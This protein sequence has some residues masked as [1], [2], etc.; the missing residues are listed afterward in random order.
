MFEDILDMVKDDTMCAKC[1]THNREC[2]IPYCD[3]LISCTSC[4]DLSQNNSK[5]C[6][7]NAFKESTTPGASA[8]TYHGMI[9]LMALI[10]PAMVFF[11]NVTKI[12]QKRGNQSPLD[13]LKED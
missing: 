11:E 9:R 2:S 10:K 4:K 6:K 8:D 5:Q 3:V 12:A 13:V 7:G 1:C